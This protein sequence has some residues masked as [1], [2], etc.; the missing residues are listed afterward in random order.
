M[1]EL[2]V[3]VPLWPGECGSAGALW[4]LERPVLISI[5]SL[6]T[7]ARGQMLEMSPERARVQP[8]DPL[9]LFKKVRTNVRFRFADVVYSLNGT[10]ITCDTDNCFDF[11]FDEVTRRDM[12][13]LRALGIAAH[14]QEEEL[15]ADLVRHMLP[16]RRKRSKSEQRIVLNEAP[17]GG[18]ERRQNRREELETQATLLVIDRG[19][20][21][22]CTLLEISASGCRLFS[23]K[24]FDLEQNMRV[25]V[26]FIGLGIPFRLAA[27]IKL[28]EEEHLVGLHFT[29]M[30]IRCRQRLIEL[31]GDLIE[32]N[33]GY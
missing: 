25:E 6:G 1:N 10:A 22:R 4:N 15:T 2:D 9:F 23:D 17:P 26:E 29:N 19:H 3:L 16:V 7:L 13:M 14:D 27:E 5:E 24:P 28:K 32:K 30:S 8:D 20:N 12:A 21:W 33:R 11:D 18:V 31:M